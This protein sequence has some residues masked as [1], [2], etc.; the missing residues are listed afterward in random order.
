MRQTLVFLSRDGYV[1]LAIYSF[2]TIAL[3]ISLIGS[4]P[5]VVDLRDT[6]TLVAFGLLVTFLLVLL[7]AFSLTPYFILVILCH[8]LRVDIKICLFLSITVMIISQCTQNF[9]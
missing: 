7:V 5:P 6:V 2:S 9:K 4:P 3:A 8:L 1:F